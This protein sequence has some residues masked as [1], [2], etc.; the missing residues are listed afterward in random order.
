MPLPDTIR[1]KLSTEAAGSISLTPVVVRDLP[2]GEL[3]D[4]I[5]P[6]TGKQI[7]RIE[8]IFLRG[9]LVSGA[10]RFRWEGWLPEREE[11]EAMLARYPDSDPNRAFNPAQ[12]T[13]II[14]TGARSRIEIPAEAAHRRSFFRRATFWSAV[15]EAIRGAAIKYVEYSYRE[16]ADRYRV[17]LSG[18]ARVQLR[19]AANSLGYSSLTRQV[20]SSDF[21]TADFLAAR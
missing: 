17:P 21:D 15:S 1:V 6:V 3:F 11:V 19:S 8:E 9:T 20:Q 18:E 2:I 5:L 10:S 7:E 16:R 14:L 4:L 12:C 13:R